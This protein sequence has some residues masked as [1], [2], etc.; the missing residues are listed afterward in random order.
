VVEADGTFVRGRNA[1]T[2]SRLS[3]G[4]YEVIFDRDVSACAYTATVARPS[5][6]FTRRALTVTTAARVGDVNGA[7]VFIHDAA[8]AAADHAFDIVTRC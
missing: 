3:T 2:T 6:R 5:P 4:S 1:A 7:F 8:G